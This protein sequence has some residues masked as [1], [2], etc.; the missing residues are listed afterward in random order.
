MYELQ[1]Q[2]FLGR[3]ALVDQRVFSDILKYHISLIIRVTYSKMALKVKALLS[4]AQ[5]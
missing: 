2:R 5:R 4:L 3:C 1:D